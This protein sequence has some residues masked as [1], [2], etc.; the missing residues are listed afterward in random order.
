MR[1]WKCRRGVAVIALAA[2]MA[3]SS[4]SSFSEP[5][6]TLVDVDFVG[7]SGDGLKF[8]M[9][10]RVENPNDFSAT[11]ERVEYRIHGDGI[12]LAVGEWSESVSVP[13]RSSVEVG[14]PFVLSWKGGRT[15]LESLFDDSEHEWQF[16]GSVELRKGPI[17]KVFLFSESGT[18]HTPS[19][20]T[21]L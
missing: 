10:A 6:V 13:A 17:T 19:G 18:I 5:D 16:E 20:L 7:I 11:I 8:E 15:V 21:N 9:M 12:E 1:I 14:V 4:C 2:A 3:L